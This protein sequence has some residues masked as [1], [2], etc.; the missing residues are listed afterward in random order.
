[1]GVV[2]LSIGLW[3]YT[4][5]NEFAGFSGGDRLYGAVFLVATGVGVL[6]VG[7]LGIVAALWESRIIATMVR[8]IQVTFQSPCVLIHNQA[9]ASAAI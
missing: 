2:S 3:L 5:N 6:I 4:S 9:L 8:L 7:F 1:M